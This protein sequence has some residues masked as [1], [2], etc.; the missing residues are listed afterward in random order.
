MSSKFPVL[1]VKFLQASCGLILAITN[2][3]GVYF[4]Y[5]TRH[6]PLVVEKRSLT[7][8]FV[9]TNLYILI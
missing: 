2:L 4:E 1:P 3:N 6:F 9:S 8:D 5:P 7:V